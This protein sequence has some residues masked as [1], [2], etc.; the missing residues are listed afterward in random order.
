MSVVKGSAHA[1]PRQAAGFAATTFRIA[2]PPTRRCL[3]E[4]T[5][6]VQTPPAAAGKRPT[7]A[8]ACIRPYRC[9]IN[10]YLI[11]MLAAR[12]RRNGP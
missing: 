9:A 4:T 8:R 7:V 11:R 1:V 10:I 5:F 12:R 3:A 2:E 6:A